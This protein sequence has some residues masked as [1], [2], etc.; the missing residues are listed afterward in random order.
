MYTNT[1]SGRGGENEIKRYRRTRASCSEVRDRRSVSAGTT[2]NS[3]IKIITGLVL[4]YR[5]HVSVRTF[6]KRLCET[7]GF[8]TSS[9]ESRV[10]RVSLYHS[11]ILSPISLALDYGKTLPK[12]RSGVP[13]PPVID[14]I[15]HCLRPPPFRQ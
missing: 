9:P 2:M 7:T 1:D 15:N 8:Y 11:R 10:H 12:K 4:V 5:R 3:I 13:S 14:H 6:N